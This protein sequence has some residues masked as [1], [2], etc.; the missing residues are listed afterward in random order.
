MTSE[1]DEFHCHENLIQ[2]P[3]VAHPAP[4][5]ALIGGGGDGSSAEELP[6]WPTAREGII[7]ELDG[8]PIEVARDH[9]QA[10]VHRRALDEPCVRT[11]IGDGLG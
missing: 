10:A 6:K 7:T 11:R 8:K 5:R 4:C 2:V 3:E 1:R 9:L